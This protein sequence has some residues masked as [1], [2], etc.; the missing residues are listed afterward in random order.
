MNIKLK[1]ILLQELIKINIGIGDTILVGRFKNKPIVVKSIG[2]DD[3]GMPTIN[4]RKVVNFRIKNH[5]NI[6]DNKE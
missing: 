4:G 3:H 1:N 5:I 2:V 6:F